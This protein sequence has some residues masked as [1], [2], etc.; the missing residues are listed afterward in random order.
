[1]LT[2]FIGSRPSPIYGDSESGIQVF[3]KQNQ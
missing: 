3:L 2:P 1:L